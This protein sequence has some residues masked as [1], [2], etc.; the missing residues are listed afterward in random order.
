MNVTPHPPPHHHQ[1]Q[2]HTHTVIWCNNSLD[3]RPSSGGIDRGCEGLGIVLSMAT[4][5]E[6]RGEQPAFGHISGI[7]R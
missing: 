2:T 4:V 7:G 6:R 3:P 5:V 1:T